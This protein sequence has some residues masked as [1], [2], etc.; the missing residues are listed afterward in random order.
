MVSKAAVQAKQARHA[1]SLARSIHGFVRTPDDLAEQMCG[2]PYSTLPD[3]R[4]RGRVLDP[5][6]GDGALVRWILQDVADPGVRVVAVE[7]DEQRYAQL[8]EF[9]AT[10]PQVQPVH[11]TLEDYLAGGPQPVDAVVMNPPWS[12][13]D[14][15]RLWVDHI[16]ACYGLLSAGGRLVSVTPHIDPPT[17]GAQ[18]GLAGL[19]AEHGGHSHVEVD[20]AAVR[21]GFPARIRLLW[22]VKP[23]TRPAPYWAIAPADDEPVDVAVPEPGP[24][25]PP[26]QRYQD[27]WDGYRP[28][29]IRSAGCCASCRRLLWVH[30]DGG[31]PALSW[32][33]C[34]VLDAQEYGKAGPTIGLCM[35]CRNDRPRY[36]EANRLAAAHWAPTAATDPARSS[37]PAPTTG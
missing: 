13:P 1:A 25:G 23:L 15:P 24:D 21:A 22:L 17:G 18:A 33:A 35:E 2:W 3:L 11:G 9:A 26:V 4:G 6:A 29:L 30:D 36:D 28:R 20:R 27:R 10:H 7:P 12:T 16:L 31:E 32:A 34:S 5:S 37:D 14:R 19:L 8:V